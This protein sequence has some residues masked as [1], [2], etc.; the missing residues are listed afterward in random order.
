MK[1]IVQDVYGSPDVLE[2]R[3][4]DRP[5]VTDDDVLV[6]VHAAAV[7]AADWHF[8]R[9]LPYVARL[10]FGLSKPKARVRGTDMA[11]RIEAVGKNVKRLQP[12]DEVFGSCRGA[13][14]EYVCAT[15]NRFVRKPAGATFEQ[16]AAIPIAGCTALGALRDVRKV[17]PGQKVLINGAGGGVGT[18]AVQIAKS[19]GADVTGVTSTRNMDLVRSLGADKVID[20]SQDDFTRKGEHYDLILDIGDRSLS[21][22]RRALVPEGT[23]VLV[24]GSAGRWVDGL[25]RVVTARML[26]AFVRQKVAPFLAR[27]TNDNMVALKE[28]VEAGKLSPVIDRTYPL[29]QTAE[30]I[31]YLEEGLVRGK[32][33]ITV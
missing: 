20:Y 30:A 16:A 2:L 14:A 7:N 19:F 11:G 17:Q 18:F 8:M 21:D 6:R 10:A 12:G 31:R 29:S 5:V 9:G 24:G 22:C 3:D 27:V 26:S 15:E 1:A 28:L 32:V 23:L 4:V 25:A 13:F 33:A